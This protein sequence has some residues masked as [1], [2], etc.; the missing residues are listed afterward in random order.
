M[1][2]MIAKRHCRRSAIKAA[3]LFRSEQGQGMTEYGL[4]MGCAAIIAFLL[5]LA[6]K[7]EV[8]V[9]FNQRITAIIDRIL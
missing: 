1:T 5:L 7:A 3:R 8:L 4:L 9:L 6:I 2:E